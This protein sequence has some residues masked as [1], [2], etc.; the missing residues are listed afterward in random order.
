[1]IEIEVDFKAGIIQPGK[2]LQGRASV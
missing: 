1:M 2:E